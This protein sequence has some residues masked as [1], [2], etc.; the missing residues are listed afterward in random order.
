MNDRP[1]LQTLRSVC[2]FCGSSN[3]TEPAF[4]AA[5]DGLGPALKAIG[6]EWV[7]YGGGST[8]LMG[9]VADSALAAGLKVYGVQPDFLDARERS[10]KRLTELEVVPSMHLR[11]Q[12]MSERADAFLTLPG[13]IGT[14]EE[15]C[16]IFTWAQLG[17]HRKPVGLLNLLGYYDPLL[18]Y[19][20]RMV[21]YGFQAQQYRD[22]VVAAPDL[23][24]LLGR[25]QTYQG[26]E[27]YLNLTPSQV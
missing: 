20:D 22:I 21:T 9:R 6:V 23:P 26:P 11:K 1:K 17:L 24:T 14:L 13:G 4:Q 7:V 16:E 15:L 8:G 2:V 25:M 12:K 18:E 27:P 19:F 10:H 5:A 3:G